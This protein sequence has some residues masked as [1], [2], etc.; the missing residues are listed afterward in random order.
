MPF[1]E[2]KFTSFYLLS[3]Q[4]LHHCLASNPKV[5]LGSIKLTY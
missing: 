1:I 3:M 2:N 4:F 5:L